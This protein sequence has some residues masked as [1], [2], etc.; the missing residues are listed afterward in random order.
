MKQHIGAVFGF[1]PV[2]GSRRWIDLG[3]FQFQPAEVMKLA[4][5]MLLAR[6]F[7]RRGKTINKPC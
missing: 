4:E 3:F 2:Q 1:D 6:L 5:I 7:N